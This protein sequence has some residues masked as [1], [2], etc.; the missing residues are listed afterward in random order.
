MFDL[1]MSHAVR[2]QYR[3]QKEIFTSFLA[4]SLVGIERQRSASD[5]QVPSSVL[6][7][8]SNDDFPGNGENAWATWSTINPG[9]YSV[10]EIIEKIMFIN[11]EEEITLSCPD[12]YGSI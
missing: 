12:N 7:S 9:R 2:L 11:M 5:E 10:M 4:L 8:Y 6:H 1:L 3:W